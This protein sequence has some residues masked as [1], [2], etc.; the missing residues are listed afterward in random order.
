M[1]PIP[2]PETFSIS[3][4]NQK[5]NY[6]FSLGSYVIQIVKEMFESQ[7]HDTWHTLSVCLSHCTFLAFGLFA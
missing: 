1:E 7:K 4:T 5:I 2:L 3:V 6:F